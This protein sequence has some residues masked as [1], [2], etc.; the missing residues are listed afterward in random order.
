MNILNLLKK[1]KNYNR[2]D[3]D[4]YLEEVNEIIRTNPNSILLDVRSPQEYKEGHLI[5]STN[6]PIYELESKIINDNN[7]KLQKKENII[8]VYCQTG[9]RSKKAI[10][11]LQKYG[12]NN[13]YHLKNGL[14][15]I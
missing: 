11:I 15:G 6:I 8:I 1:I 13:L 2:E 9:T 14:D 7:N 12:F 3:N 5:G 4:I 10:K